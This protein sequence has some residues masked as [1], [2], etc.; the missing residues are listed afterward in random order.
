MINWLAP[1]TKVI[2][3]V[4]GAYSKKQERKTLKE[5]AQ[6][7]ANMAKQAGDKEVTLT[8]AEWESLSVQKSDETWKDEYVTLVITFLIIGILFGHFLSIFGIGGDI[9]AIT[10]SSIVD[11][12]ELI[13]NYGIILQWVVLAAIGIKG[14]RVFK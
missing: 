13:P 12:K 5:Q 3:T 11:L 14:I 4:A 1:V 7:K 9:V 10:K 6:I 2:D 8:D